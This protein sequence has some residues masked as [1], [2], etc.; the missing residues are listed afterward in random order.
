[1]VTLAI[2]LLAG[3]AVGLAERASRQ[4]I[5]GRAYRNAAMDRAGATD[6]SDTR[7]T[8]DTTDAPN[9]PDTTPT[10]EGRP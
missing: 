6:A 4:M 7:D 10:Q 1:M 5:D 8:P 2:G 9:A 3:P